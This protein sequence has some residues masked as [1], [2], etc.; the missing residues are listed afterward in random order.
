MNEEVREN[1]AKFLCEGYFNVLM[2]AFEE[3]QDVLPI[4][5]CIINFMEKLNERTIFYKLDYVFNSDF[6]DKMQVE[7]D[8]FIGK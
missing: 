3:Q 2:T 5:M 6:I 1:I 7:V 4:T 8:R